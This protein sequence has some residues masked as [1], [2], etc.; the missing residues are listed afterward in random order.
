MRKGGVVVVFL[1]AAALLLAPAALAAFGHDAAYIRNGTFGGGNYAFPMN[2]SVNNSL[3]VNGSVGIGANATAA[4]LTVTGSD[5]DN[6]F[7]I[8]NAQDRE[9]QSLDASGAGNAGTFKLFNGSGIETVRFN[10]Q[11]TSFFNA[12]G[13]FL[14]IGTDNP[15]FTLHVNASTNVNLAAFSLEV[16]ESSTG[17]NFLLYNQR[18]ANSAYQFLD[19]IS[20]SDGTPDNEFILRGDGTGLADGSWTS[21]ADY[22]EYF[23]SDDVT[24]VSGELV[25]V[26][27]EIK[28]KRCALGEKLIGIVSTKPGIVG[29]Y[30]DDVTDAA[31]D[32]EQDAHWKI[33]GIMGQIPTKVSVSKGVIRAGDE[34]MLGSDGVAIKGESPR[35]L[36]MIALEDATENATIRVLAK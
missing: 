8:R 25:C 36:F 7:E 1:L 3:I 18:V 13:R 28:V 27:G 16:G 9:V 22:A 23:Y 31:E 10:A 21:P 30:A 12:P 11:G 26:A 20:D 2:L 17:A 4:R 34:L 32:Y 5:N 29:V 14:G 6:I 15:S 24:L 33:I 19:A 35:S